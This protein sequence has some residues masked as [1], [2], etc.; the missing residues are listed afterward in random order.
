MGNWKIIA[1][2]ASCWLLV[3]CTALQDMMGVEPKG[4]AA[5]QAPVV[6]SD[7]FCLIAQ[8]ISWSSKDT[9]ETIE[10]VKELN[11]IGTRLCH[12]QG[13]PT[14]PAPKP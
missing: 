9:P 10:Q 3:G 2:A 1:C 4:T 8:P 13:H 5:A 6:N 12:W 11:A 14:L 7:S